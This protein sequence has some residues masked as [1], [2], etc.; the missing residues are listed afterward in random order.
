MAS[1]L[2]GIL[3]SNPDSSSTTTPLPVELPEELKPLVTQTA[4]QLTNLQRKHPLSSLFNYAPQ[5]ITGLTDVE[6]GLYG[7]QVSLAGKMAMTAPEM[8]ALEQI[9]A[10]TSGPIGSSPATLAAL[11]N[12]EQ[13]SKPGI[14]QDLALAGL[15][16]AGAFPDVISG[17]RSAALLPMFQQE[18]QNRANVIP[19]LS[20]IGNTV[21]GR[22]R[23]DL[24]TAITA[25]GVPRDISE[26]R[27]QANFMEQQRIQNM[28]QLIGLSPS[29]LFGKLIPGA[30]S[31]VDASKQGIWTG[32]ANK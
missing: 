29:G 8:A 4:E 27:N 19:Q 21:A 6:K 9:N 10:L 7:Q 3:G 17:A 20:Q 23:S 12:F 26:A 11:Q 25:A 13:M 18:I 32:I 16:R 31:T 15:S 24:S 28:T 1:F 2:G 5:P 14:A 30:G 22:E